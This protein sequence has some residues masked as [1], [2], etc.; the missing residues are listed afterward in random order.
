MAQK[1]RKKETEK[2]VQKN[3]N[4][5]DKIIFAFLAAFLSIIGFLIALILKKDDKYVIFYAKQSLVIFV[6]GAIA[7]ILG[8]AIK[9]LPIIG[10]IIYGALFILIFI[11]WFLSWIYALSGKEKTIPIIRYWAEK[12]NL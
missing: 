7:G 10:T 4:S 2:K 1:K 9:F 3:N 8:N 5:D 11:A 6:I 12:I